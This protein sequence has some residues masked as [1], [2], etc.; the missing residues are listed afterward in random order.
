MNGCLP[1]E[2]SSGF[3]D[4]WTELILITRSIVWDTLRFSQDFFVSG[5][6]RTVSGWSSD[7]RPMVVG[8][9]FSREN[10]I[11]QIS[12]FN[13][14]G[15]GPC[16]AIPSVQAVPPQPWPIEMRNLKF[17]I[18]LFE[19][20][21]IVSC[22]NGCSTIIRRRTSVDRPARKIQRKTKCFSNDRS[23]HEDQSCPRIVKTGAI[24]K[25]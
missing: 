14:L 20:H 16:R 13:W 15:L 3:D 23:R 24:L 9:L 19:I 12:N 6:R 5:G 25:G 22:E 4:F 10:F 8:R 1:L 21:R 18:L 11:F 2:D 7:G 17:K